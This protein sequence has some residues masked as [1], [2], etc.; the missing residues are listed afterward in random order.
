MKMKVCQGCYDAFM[1]SEGAQTEE[2]KRLIA[3]GKRAGFKFRIVPP[4]RCENP[5]H[6]ND[7]AQKAGRRQQSEEEPS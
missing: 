3:M 5:T 7:E 1:Q 6:P 4:D 2:G